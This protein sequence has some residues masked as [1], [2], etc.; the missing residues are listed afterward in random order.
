M[1][2]D[3]NK[4]MLIS[5]QCPECLTRDSR[6]QS[7][8]CED[9]RHAGLMTTKTRCGSSRCESCG[10]E[11]SYL[12]GSTIDTV[13]HGLDP[14]FVAEAKRWSEHGVFSPADCV[15]LAWMQLDPLGEMALFAGCDVINN[16]GSFMVDTVCLMVR[17]NRLPMGSDPLLVLGEVLGRLSMLERRVDESIS[18]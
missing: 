7:C 8:E 13:C 18:R 4:S 10:W 15:F 12:D 6:K 16:A 17:A 3:V 1:V 5:W 11:G 9:E 2:V 14:S